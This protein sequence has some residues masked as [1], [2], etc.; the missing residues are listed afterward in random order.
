MAG[1]C[2]ASE[3][4]GGARFQSCGSHKVKSACTAEK[5]TKMGVKSTVFELHKS[6][7]HKCLCTINFL[8]NENKKKMFSPPKWGAHPQKVASPAVRTGGPLIQIQCGGLFIHED[9]F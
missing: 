8:N 4:G 5:F 3:N 2:L 6:S 1:P 7:K 9:F